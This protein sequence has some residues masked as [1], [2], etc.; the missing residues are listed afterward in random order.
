VGALARIG[1]LE[2][3]R[4]FAEFRLLIFGALLIVM[5]LARPEGLW[6]SAIRQREL[7]GGDD[8]DEVIPTQGVSVTARG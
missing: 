8:E 4:E 3:L 2:V 7:K 1:L 5:M 6:P